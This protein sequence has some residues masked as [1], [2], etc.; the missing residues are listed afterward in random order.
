MCNK[1][2]CIFLD[3][4][5][6]NYFYIPLISIYSIIWG[7]W[8]IYQI[9]QYKNIPL[10]KTN[11][12]TDKIIECYKPSE[13]AIE[14]WR[15]LIRVDQNYDTPVWYWF[16][17]IPTSFILP[18][19][20]SIWYWWRGLCNEKFYTYE[21]FTTIRNITGIMSLISIITACFMLQWY[22]LMSNIMVHVMTIGWNYTAAANSL[23]INMLKI[24]N[25]NLRNMTSDQIE[26]AEIQLN[27][28]AIIEDA[29]ENKTNKDEW[30]GTILRPWKVKHVLLTFLWMF[31]YVLV[32][33]LFTAMMFIEKQKYQQNPKYQNT[34]Y[35]VFVCDKSSNPPDSWYT[36][37]RN[38]L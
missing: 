3:H 31:T 18:S 16:L 26:A 22:A 30:L 25:G 37:L 23:T 6:L 17:I 15:W 10:Q 21:Y 32:F 38:M 29:V 34:Y 33:Y 19:L 4:K 12:I 35:T 1:R 9:L 27:T 24:N 13:H 28:M 14:Q 11:C 7:C 5:K 36:F 2:C 20:I 8:W